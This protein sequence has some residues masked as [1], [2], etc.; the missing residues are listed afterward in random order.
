MRNCAAELEAVGIR[1]TS[2]AYTIRKHAREIQKFEVLIQ[3]LRYLAAI[4]EADNMVEAVGQCPLEDLSNELVSTLRH[5]D[6][7]ASQVT[8]PHDKKT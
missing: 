5:W 7:L 3:K 6:E 1:I 2:D 4:C 8:L